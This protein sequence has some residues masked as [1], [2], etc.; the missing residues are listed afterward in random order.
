MLLGQ[1]SGANLIIVSRHSEQSSESQYWHLSLPFLFS[2]RPDASRPKQPSQPPVLVFIDSLPDHDDPQ[3]MKVSVQYAE[4]RL[5]ELLPTSASE[6]T[7]TT[8]NALPHKSVPAPQSATKRGFWGAGKGEIWMADDWDSP[9]TNDE[10]ANHT[11]W[12]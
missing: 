3:P 1:H 5:T 12:R 10:I 11:F 9:K 7:E 8:G 2:L 6:Q 4:S